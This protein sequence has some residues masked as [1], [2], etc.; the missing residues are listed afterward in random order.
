MGKENDIRIYL[1]KKRFGSMWKLVSINGSPLIL[2]GTE[3]A[4]TVL[5]RLENSEK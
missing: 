3:K 5:K 4:I 2:K 1:V